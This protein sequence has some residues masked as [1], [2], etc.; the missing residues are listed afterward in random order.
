V[1]EH[2]TRSQLSAVGK[3]IR[4]APQLRDIRDEDLTVLDQFRA[5]HDAVLIAVHDELARFFHE[6]SAFPPD[7]VP[8]TSRLKTVGAIV[9]KLRRSKT[10]LERMQ[11]VAGARVVLPSLELQDEALRIATSRLFAE[12]VVAKKD[13]RSEADRY[14]Y[15]PLHVV[16][17]VDGLL[18]EIQIRTVA[19]DRWA[20]IVETL[21][22]S[23]DWD[24]KHGHGPAEWLE[25]L[26]ALSDAF[27]DADL[28]NPYSIPPLPFDE[29]LDHG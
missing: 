22:K 19:Q 2:P 6:L 17:R 14:G 25:W 13:G 10:S 7:V 18:A 12:R 26:H 27:R 8:V 24:L 28:G 5:R 1:H 11:D 15:R 29:D 16:V 4:H 9:A 3:R 21:D 23:N 20:Q